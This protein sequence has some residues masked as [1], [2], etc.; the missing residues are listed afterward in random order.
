MYPYTGIPNGVLIIGISSKWQHIHLYEYLIV[1]FPDYFHPFHPGKVAV[2]IWAENETTYIYSNSCRHTVVLCII[3]IL[4]I[5]YTKHEVIWGGGGGG[6]SQGSSS[7]GQPEHF[8]TFLLNPIPLGS[9]RYLGKGGGLLLSSSYPK[10]VAL[11]HV[12]FSIHTFII[13]YVY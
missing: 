1:L 10:N 8:R 5:Y 2:R 11:I 7:E 6:G 4:Y 3:R 13:S 12:A 9:S